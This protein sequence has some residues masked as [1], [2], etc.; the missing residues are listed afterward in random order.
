MCLWTLLQSSASNHDGVDDGTPH[1]Q[2]LASPDIEEATK[3]RLHQE[4]AALD[5][6]ELKKPLN[7]NSRT[8]SLSSVT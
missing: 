8:S 2:L 1:Q 7:I 5:L 3:T 6:F 4:H